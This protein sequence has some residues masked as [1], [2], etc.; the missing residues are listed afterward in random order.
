VLAPLVIIVIFSFLSRAKLGVGVK[1]EFTI[2][3]YV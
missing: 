2:Q 3:P 1:W